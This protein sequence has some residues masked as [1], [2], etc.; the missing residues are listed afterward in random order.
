MLLVVQLYEQVVIFP[1]GI[2]IFS[3][4][5]SLRFGLLPLLFSTAL[6][7]WIH[8]RHQRRRWKLGRGGLAV[9]H[10]LEDSRMLVHNA[11]HVTPLPWNRQPIYPTHRGT[12]RLSDLE[13][14][15][16]GWCL[17]LPASMNPS[18]CFQSDEATAR[19]QTKDVSPFH[20]ARCE[21]IPPTKKFRYNGVQGEATE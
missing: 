19:R 2:Y 1:V 13:N 7:H 14:R 6:T 15:P 12:L 10:R 18:Q 8:V 17:R 16:V 4:L 21:I 20:D 9:V 11:C 5:I 3:F